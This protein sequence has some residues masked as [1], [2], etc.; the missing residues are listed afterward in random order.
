MDPAVN[1]T[2]TQ[3][4]TQP[5]PQ[6]E[7]TQ[8]SESKPKKS[9]KKLL[10]VVAIIIAIIISGAGAIAL[11]L[12]KTDSPKTT[13]TSAGTIETSKNVQVG[14]YL[15]IPELGVRLKL[16]TEIKDAYYI[17]DKN[18]SDDD[19]DW[20]F[21]S[22]K[23]LKELEPGCSAENESKLSPGYVSYF[24]DPNEPW[25]IG[26]DS[27]ISDYYP[28]NFKLGDRYVFYSTY[29]QAPCY[30]IETTSEE[31]TKQIEG[32]FKLFKQARLEGINSPKT[33][34]NVPTDK[35]VVEINKALRVLCPEPFKIEKATKESI[36]NSFY[37]G[38]VRV[39]IHCVDPQ[40]GGGGGYLAFFQR[41]SDLTWK[42]ILSGQE[43]PSCDVAN[44]LKIPHQVL[45]SCFEGDNLVSNKN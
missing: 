25:G 10:I 40:E 30:Q 36:S 12:L 37:N 22:T 35:D 6:P 34:T 42:K 38:F 32:I 4:Q 1:S 44:N 15:E 19:R 29:Q 8:K 39:G 9:K 41:Q 5:N 20:A 7:S 21:I 3:A 23:T 2:Q 16:P 43:P 33:S 24:T 11:T 17:I 45:E 26:D 28:D 14:E 13:P 18:F 31:K 27:T